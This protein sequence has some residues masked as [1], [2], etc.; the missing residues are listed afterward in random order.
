MGLTSILTAVLVMTM[1]GALL[2]PTV[3]NHGRPFDGKDKDQP[4][5]Q[6][7][8]QPQPM[9]QPSPSL[10]PQ[11]AA[12]AVAVVAALDRNFSSASRRGKV[13]VTCYRHRNC[14]FFL[15]RGRDPGNY[16]LKRWLWEVPPTPDGAG[17]AQNKE[18]AEKHKV[19]ARR[20][21]GAK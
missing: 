20:R 9:S 13:L 6:P 2:R 21:W 10:Q 17:S 4:P 3:R 14:K 1:T 18:L 11:L 19:I 7:S 8:L 16:E 12:V 15:G 5:S